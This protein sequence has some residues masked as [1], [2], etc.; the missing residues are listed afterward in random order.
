MSNFIIERDVLVKYI[1]KQKDVIIPNGIRVI[2]SQ[3]FVNESVDND[4]VQTVVFPPSLEDIKDKAFYGNIALNKVCFSKGLKHIGKQAFAGCDSLHELSIPEGVEW[5]E[6]QAFSDCKNLKQIYIPGSLSK[7]SKSPY[8]PYAFERLSGLEEITIAVE[9]Q[10][11]EHVS[12]LASGLFS[13]QSLADYYIKGKIKTCEALDKAMFKRLNTKANR[14]WIF[15]KLLMAKDI[16]SAS[17]FLSMIK[18]MSA[19]EIDNYLAMSDKD[20]EFRALFVEYKNGIYSPDDIAQAVLIQTEKNMGIK[21]WTMAD[22]KKIYKINNS[23]EITGYKDTSAYATI[24]AKIKNTSIEIGPNAFKYCDFLEKVVI[25][26]GVTQIAN[27]AFN[28]CV[29]LV[30]IVI[31][32]TLEKI[33]ASAFKNCANLKDVYFSNKI[34]NIGSKAFEGCE[35]LVIH[36]LAGTKIIKYAIANNICYEEE[37]R[38]DTNLQDK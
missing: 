25:E 6:T 20:P 11:K 14:S 36:A 24:P 23:G 19:E 15:K 1:G 34:T 3:A 22:W 10:N 12:F 4:L 9:P 13:I 37:V 27:S 18:K 35:K 38:L 7:L 26:E 17:R 5:I 28:G 8:N 21:E 32:S 33:G 29:N 2:E 30:E 31:P 16:E